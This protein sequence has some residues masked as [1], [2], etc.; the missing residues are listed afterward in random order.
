LHRH[1]LDALSLSSF[2]SVLNRMNISASC[3]IFY[4]EVMVRDLRLLI[5]TFFPRLPRLFL[6]IGVKLP[7]IS[8]PTLFLSF[9]A[10]I[11]VVVPEP[12][13]GS[14]TVSPLTENIRISL[15]A[16]SSGNAAVLLASWLVIW[17][18]PL[19]FQIWVNQTSR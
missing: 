8:Y 16:I 2:F 14:R 7:S 15:F 11:L 13:K 19:R 6:I 3:L 12:K 10:A 17:R 18:V 5:I 1:H 9:W 4:E